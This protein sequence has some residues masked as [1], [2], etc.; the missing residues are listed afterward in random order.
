MMRTLTTFYIVRHGQTDWNAQKIVQ[1]H[2]NSLLNK[3]GEEQAAAA[4]AELRHVAFDGVFSSDLLRAK[5]TAEII[6]AERDLAVKTTE[7]IRERLYGVY[8][9]KPSDE[10]KKYY[11]KLDMLLEHE[12]SDYRASRGIE[13]DQQIVSRF[14]TFLRE[15]SVVYPGKTILVVSHGGIMRLLLTHVAGIADKGRALRIENT[16]YIKLQTDG[17]DFFIRETRRILFPEK[18]SGFTTS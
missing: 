1:G 18:V 11:A 4:A 7:L 17:A 10:L 6:V 9:G 16:G 2:S 15:T 14:I 3:V 12:R 5:R 8:E 13:G